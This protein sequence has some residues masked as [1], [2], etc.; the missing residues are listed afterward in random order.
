MK[1]H[2][3]IACAAVMVALPV[4]ANAG[5]FGNP[6]TSEG[7]IN[8][9]SNVTT[10]FSYYFTDRLSEPNFRGFRGRGTFRIPGETD[11]AKQP[12]YNLVE[13]GCHDKEDTRELECTLTEATVSASAGSPDAS[14]PSCVLDIDISTFEMKE[15]SR[16]VFVGVAH[17]GSS[18]SCFN[19]TLTIN[20]N[21]KRVSLSFERTQYAD[22][23]DRIRAGTCG[24]TPPRTQMLMNCTA[25][26]PH[27]TYKRPAPGERICDFEEH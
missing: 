14:S 22:N 18:T 11:E 4:T 27:Y 9:C 3:A 12:M 5:L 6:A 17:G 8:S 1:R 2:A 21:T 20:R 23:Y 15:L 24:Q 7:H 26:V 13:L 10:N 16:G 19:T 25:W